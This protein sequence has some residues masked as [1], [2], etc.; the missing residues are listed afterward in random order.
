MA[1]VLLC[2][3]RPAIA[4][5]HTATIPVPLVDP[6]MLGHPGFKFEGGVP[7]VANLIAHG[8]GAR[9]GHLWV[10]NTGKS[11]RIVGQVDGN[12]PDWPK[13][14]DSILSKDH[15][16]VWLAAADSVEMPPLVWSQWPIY[17]AQSADECDEISS[18]AS[19]GRDHSDNCR[20]W[21]SEQE[22]YRPALPRLF[23]RQWLLTDPF[24]E[25]SYATPAYALVMKNY[26]TS[27][28]QILEPQGDVPVP[29]VIAPGQAGLSVRN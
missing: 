19:P 22:K 12:A 28:A 4:Q 21:F 20:D 24:S 17:S 15:V 16:E 3:S 13:D 27:G 5:D 7:L 25:E 11:L 6:G 1:G 23:V 10:G 8:N 29:V 18:D 14:K 2:W 26:G 9:N